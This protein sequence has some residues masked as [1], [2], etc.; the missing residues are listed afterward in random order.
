ML[1][2]LAEQDHIAGKVGHSNSRKFFV[3]S[4]AAATGSPSW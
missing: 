1:V 2:E 3:S 4:G